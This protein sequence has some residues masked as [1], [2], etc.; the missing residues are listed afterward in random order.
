MKTEVSF[1]ETEVVKPSNLGLHFFL[2]KSL[3]NA[4]LYSE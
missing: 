3:D 4:S 2:L 1:T